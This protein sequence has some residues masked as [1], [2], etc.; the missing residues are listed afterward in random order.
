MICI[1]SAISVFLPFIFSIWTSSPINLCWTTIIYGNSSKCL[2][3]SHR[4]IISASQPSLIKQTPS[5]WANVV[6]FS[7]GR[8]ITTK[9]AIHNR[10][11]FINKIIHELRRLIQDKNFQIDIWRVQKVCV[12][13]LQARVNNNNIKL[14]PLNN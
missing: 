7:V 2:F 5:S 1:L 8:N 9:L 6:F 3:N 14:N 13:M 11:Y 12:K 10:K 4:T